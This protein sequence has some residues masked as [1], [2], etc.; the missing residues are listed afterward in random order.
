MSR[1]KVLKIDH[2]DPVLVGKRNRRIFYLYSIITVLILFLINIHG[3]LKENAHTTISVILPVVFV[4]FI[5][6][7]WRLKRT[8]KKIKTIG[9]IEFTTSGIKKRIG[10]TLVEYNYQ[11]IKEIE[12]SKH[13]PA[14]S[15]RESKSGYF[16]YILKINF[17]DSGSESIVVADRSIDMKKD[18]SIIETLKTLKR[19]CSFE[20]KLP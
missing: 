3:S 8:I 18:I 9:D 12:V 6:L 4:I 20:I 17:H 15:L 5:L 14:T 1:F 13:I 19:I 16:S 11:M 10:D 7:I 2:F